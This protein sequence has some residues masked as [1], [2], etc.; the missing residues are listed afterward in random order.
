M[1]VSLKWLAELVDYP[2]ANELVRQFNLHSQEIESL[3]AVLETKGLV[4]GLVTDTKS[5]PDADKLRVCQVDIGAHTLQIVCGA[6]NVATGQKV[7]VAPVGTILPGL[8]IKA[9]TIR[10]VESQGMICSLPEIGLEPPFGDPSGIEVLPPESVLGTNPVDALYLNDQ[11]MEIGLTPNRADLLSM[12]GV[13][14]DTAAIFSSKVRLPDVNVSEKGPKNPVQVKIETDGC[15]SYYA[16]VLEHVVIKPSPAWLKAR[17]IACGV[18]PINNVV[19]ITNYI[20]LETGQPLHAFDLGKFKTNEVVV[21]D[22]KASETI[23]TLDDIERTLHAE[24]VVITNGEVATAIGGVKGGA[25][26]QIDDSTVQVLLESAT[27]APSRI[28]KTAQRL[29]LRSEASS[30]F[31]KG[32]D[33][34]RTLLAMERAT[35]MLIELADATVYQGIS[36]VSNRK[37]SPVQIT[38]TNE[39]VERALGTTIPRDGIVSIFDRLG[40]DSTTSSNSYTVD[41]PSRRQDVVFKH[42]VIEE[43]ARIYGLNNIPSSVPLSSSIG[44][45]KP[46]QQLR[47]F[48][49]RRFNAMGFYDVITYTLMDPA[50]VEATSR[51]LDPV[52][53]IQSPMSEKKAVLR[54][55]VLA[56]LLQVVNYHHARQLFDV[57]VFEMSRIHNID[58]DEVVGF[59]LSGNPAE[60]RWQSKNPVSFY[61][62]KGVVHSLL[63]H[64]GER[65]SYRVEEVPEILHPGQ[66]ARIYLDEVAI[67]VIGKVHPKW[68]KTFEIKDTFVA[69]ITISKL[70]I[71][72]VIPLYKAVPKVPSVQRELTFITTQPAAAL[73][74][75]LQNAKTT[76]VESIDVYDL[77]RAEE[78]TITVSVKF[79]S[80]V[81]TLSSDQ[82]QADVDAMVASAKAAGFVFKDVA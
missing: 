1:N 82:V 60:A 42:D 67:G 53:A 9:A 17:L 18:R 59:A 20:M 34:E 10:G 69:E 36:G 50:F 32:V 13:A 68:M 47:R 39:E 30:R 65:I 73:L 4:V 61:D 46:F 70:G 44:G 23:L 52:I 11:V 35:T 76:Y 74:Q 62:L 7:V 54:Q 66:S 12:M 64:F 38:I 79:Q 56:G 71:E 33:P 31:E 78:T 49:R 41:I 3:T 77:Y 28:R 25:N 37:S 27:F 75:S 21:R 26:T 29:D 14:Y 63:S 2:S 8:E 55:S 22:A 19:D 81:A 57:R 72:E 5:H 40:F 43:I 45:L 16:R 48:L 6:P 80:Y 24:D 58:N 51:D 15:T